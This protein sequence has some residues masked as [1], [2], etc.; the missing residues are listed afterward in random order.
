MLIDMHA[1]LMDGEA[2]EG[3]KNLLD[4][5]K[6]MGISKIMVSSLGSFNPGEEEVERLNE[7][8]ASFMREAPETVLGWCY[9]NPRNRNSMDV[10]KRCV[11][12]NGMRGMKLWVA[13][14]CDDPL[15][16]P[17]ARWC[18]E[19]GL[20]VLVHAFYKRVGQLPCESL[21]ENVANL[22]RL[23]PETNILMAHLGANCLRELKPVADCPNVWADFSG[24]IVRRDDLNYAKKM[25]G[26]RR[27]VF[28]TDMP[29]F[30]GQLSFGQMEEADFTPEEREWVS[31]KNAETLLGEVF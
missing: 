31:H 1:H 8:T 13:T 15:V 3:K 28:G 16:L 6:A 20:P 29:L 11:Q 19:N 12:Q 4:A 22:A 2:E 25:L 24:S 7:Q 10:L 17:L 9:V 27:L 23:C 18:G 14:F 5:C 30:P 26:A 21:G